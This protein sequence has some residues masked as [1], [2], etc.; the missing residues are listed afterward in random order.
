MPLPSGAR[1][2]SYEITHVLGAGGMGE[3]YRARDTRLGRDVALKIILESFA[4]DRDRIARFEREAKVLASISHPNI[5]GLYGMEEFDAHQFLVMELVEGETL[6]DRLRRGPLAG[7]AD[8]ARARAMTA[9]LGIRR[10]GLGPRCSCSAGDRIERPG[11]VEFR[12]QN[13]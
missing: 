11:W 7:R 4:S 9:A 12:Y 3:V 6:A 5:A 1:F 2:G 13:P 10:S 8:A